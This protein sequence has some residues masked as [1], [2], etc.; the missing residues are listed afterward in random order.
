MKYNFDDIYDEYFDRI[1][2]KVYSMVNNEKDAEDIVQNAF[3]SVYK[4]LKKFNKKSNI[5]T[6]IYKIAI[7]K[8]YD[9][10]RKKKEEFELKDNHICDDVEIIDDL[11]FI[12]KKIDELDE[13]NKKIV[14]LHTIYGYKFREI[15]KLLK[16]KLSTV[17]AKYYK[18]LNLMGGEING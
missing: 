5:Y 6:W 9:F 14:V 7:N 15:G 3:I 10:F 2:N 4:N 12:N 18:A 1:F 11:I 16:M 17:K 13:E 8:T